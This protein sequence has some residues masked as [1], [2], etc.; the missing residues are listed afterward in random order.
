MEATKPRVPSNKIQ[1]NKGILNKLKGFFEPVKKTDLPQNSQNQSTDEIT[2]TLNNWISDSS[3]DFNQNT[4]TKLF[5]DQQLEADFKLIEAITHF[6]K[7]TEPIHNI[8]SIIETD[9]EC[10]M[11]ENESKTSI[12]SLP[13]ELLCKII[14]YLDFNDRRNASLVCKK[15]RSAFLESYYL[16]DIMIKANNHLFLSSRPSS[17]SSQYSASKHRAASSM[18]LTSYSS[19]STFNFYFY[20]ILVNLEFENDSAD[21]N[22]LVKNLQ[23][24]NSNGEVSLP[25][26]RNLKF[27]KTTMSSKTLIEILREAPNLKSLSII[28]CDSLFM[29]GFL[30]Y[31]LTQ[32]SSF[33]LT[34][35]SHLSLSKNR[36]LTDFLINL[37]LNS[38][39]SLES[40]DI[41]FCLM[42]KKNFKSIIS[43]PDLNLNQSASAVVLTIENLLKQEVKLENLK[44]INLSGIEIFN[45]DEES[46]L[47][48]VE[49]LKNLE[50]IYLSNLPFLKVDTVMK[51]FEKIPNLK[52]IDLNG[53]IQI[54]DLK[55]NSVEHCLETS[56]LLH[57]DEM[58]RLEIL[59]LSKAKIND[60]RLFIEQIQHLSKLT[61]LDLSCA[62]FQRSFGTVDRL[63]NFIEQFAFNLSKCEKIE[64]LMLSYCDFI[65]TDTFIRIISKKLTKL[66]HLDLRNCSQITDQSLHVISTFLTKL[67][68]LDL[69]WCQNISDYGLCKSI[70]YNKDQQLLN[71]FN[72]HMNGSCR[73][74][75]KYT[76]QPFLLIKTK[77]ELSSENRK[78]FC[79]CNVNDIET[80]ENGAFDGGVEDLSFI[81]EIKCDASLKNLKFLKVLK[82]ESCINVSDIGLS[83][84]VNLAKLNELDI[85]LCTN[86]TGDFIVSGLELDSNKN[87][88]RQSFNNFRTVNLNQ[89][90]KLKEDNL[91]L[92]V[93][94][95]PNLR[96]LSISAIP[97][98]SN[99]LVECLLRLKKMLVSVDISFCQ[100]INETCV[101]KY[102]QF[103]YNEFGLREFF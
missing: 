103:L 30:T 92:L 49:K 94:N 29:S 62:M 20:S 24:R 9:Q 16:K 38:T 34:H 48:L 45:H 89:C 58:S 91:I 42:T 95:S 23:S 18:A 72:K 2:H 40:L 101:E 36:Y 87:G 76:D 84:G 82:L 51:I 5:N 28:Q 85:K 70:E 102:E 54:D 52:L 33:D 32:G 88:S 4:Q 71:E 77:M 43:S 80:G 74:V 8:N 69:S 21:A 25:K 6:L 73:C 61:Y 22:L 17:S 75:R 31:S 26:L 59:K 86:I 60:P 39:N 79:G 46:L 65:V 1:N 27:S 3:D 11:S 98:I 93:E 35:L 10:L 12:E 99:R 57:N 7:E 100:S 68:H 90:I 81:E 19:V 44:S 64:T 15:W 50:E 83:S 63:N 78:Q 55:Q 67:V 66:K 41:S 14:D 97:S 13:I 96:E 37:F 56:R 47:K 53:S